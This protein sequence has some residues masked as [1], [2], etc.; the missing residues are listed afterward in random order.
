MVL[1]HKNLREIIQIQNNSKA[2][3]VDVPLIWRNTALPGDVTSPLEVGGCDSNELHLIP[4]IQSVARYEVYRLVSD[5]GYTDKDDVIEEN[6]TDIQLLTPNSL[7]G[8]H[9]MTLHSIVKEQSMFT[10][11][12]IFRCERVRVATNNSSS[13]TELI[14]SAF[15][16]IPDDN[17]C[18]VLWCIEA[19]NPLNYDLFC[20]I[21]TEE[22]VE[23]FHKSFDEKMLSCVYKEDRYMSVISTANKE[24]CCSIVIK[25]FERFNV[26]ILIRFKDGSSRV[27]NLTTIDIVNRLQ[28]QSDINYFD[29][30]FWKSESN[31]LAIWQPLLSQIMLMKNHINDGS[32]EYEPCFKHNYHTGEQFKIYSEKVNFQLIQ[33]MVCSIITYLELDFDSEGL[34]RDLKLRNISKTNYKMKRSKSIGREWHE[35]S[36]ELSKFSQS[37]HP[38]IQNEAPPPY[39]ICSGHTYFGKKGLWWNSFSHMNGGCWNTSISNHISKEKTQPLLILNRK[40]CH[41]PASASITLKLETPLLS[42]LCKVVDNKLITPELTKAERLSNDIPQ[43]MAKCCILPS[44]PANSSVDNLSPSPILVVHKGYNQTLSPDQIANI[45]I[46]D[47]RPKYGPGAFRKIIEVEYFPM[48]FEVKPKVFGISE[49]A[50]KPNV[51]RGVGTYLHISSTYCTQNLTRQRGPDDIKYLMRDRYVNI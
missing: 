28:L 30:T 40:S 31:E 34:P 20:L 36:Y 2:F 39:S 46:T 27:I 15:C 19:M 9:L 17:E 50:A 44:N 45:E 13:S 21:I 5:D 26:S 48:H 14:L 42:P 37:Q 25:L 32:I 23:E 43:E 10:A 1:E 29:E 41:S 47:D 8:G 38:L 6:L 3:P 33:K 24:I 22:V 18:A 4:Q 7:D 11:H 51:P 35:Q 12:T 49:N 16:K